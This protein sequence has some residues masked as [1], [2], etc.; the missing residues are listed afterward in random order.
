[1][2]SSSGGDTPKHVENAFNPNFSVRRHKFGRSRRKFV[3]FAKKKITK[4]PV[5]DAF[6]PFLLFFVVIRRLR[7]LNKI[8]LSAK[9]VRV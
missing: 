6:L 9:K 4:T 2:V 7:F 8:Q 5:Y 1:M 3:L